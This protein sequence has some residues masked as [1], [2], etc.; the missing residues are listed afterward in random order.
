MTDLQLM[1]ALGQVQDDFILEA[2]HT[3]RAASGM[4]FSR[5]MGLIAAIICLLLVLVGCGAVVY[6]QLAESPVFDLPQVNG[7]DVPAEDIILTVIDPTPSGMTL[8]V[9]IENFGDLEKAVFMLRDGSFTLERNTTEGWKPVDILL[10]EVEK[11]ADDLA[12]DGHSQWYV[13][14]STTYGLLEPGHYRY[15][16][17]ILEGNE[18]VSAEF[19]I[20]EKNQTE[21]LD[22]VDKLLKTDSYHIRITTE[23]TFTFPEG[24]SAEDEE[25]YRKDY[26]SLYDDYIKCGEDRMLGYYEN[27]I[28]TVGML[29]LDGVKYK[30]SYE[31]ENRKNPM[32]GWEVCPDMDMER[33]TEWTGLLSTE[34]T[35]LQK[36]E[37]GN[38]E[39]IFI[40]YSTEDG[41]NV[42]SNTV[43]TVSLLSTDPETIGT[44]FSRQDT[45][46]IR[47]FNWE[48][49]QKTRKAL[50]VDFQ[51]TKSCPI[52]TAADAIAR[53]EAERTVECS[54]I[55]VYRDEGAGMWAVEYQI[56]SGYQGYQ[57]IYMDDDGITQM[58]SGAGSKVEEWKDLYPDP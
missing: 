29:Y 6:L 16:T 5:K 11:Q 54:D 9:D 2:V 1:E 28:M 26:S 48:E 12:T 19:T 18:A 14:W 13:S 25:I 23:R 53:A 51:N 17:Y 7:S 31:G 50:D 56:L 46:T 47:E 45:N 55:R 44:I 34:E 39:K 57:F 58:V 40:R 3:E 42:Q 4:R 24:V 38:I 49:S 15:T 10:D 33:L 20:E 36:D 8:K 35:Q 27:G 30:M 43:V 41:N 21:I 32:I 37:N 52:V 22:T